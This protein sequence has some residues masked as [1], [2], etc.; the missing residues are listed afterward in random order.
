MCQVLLTH[1]QSNLMGCVMD[2]SKRKMSF[3]AFLAIIVG[4]IT[5]LAGG[6]HVWA[7][8]PVLGS[9]AQM[10]LAERYQVRRSGD[11]TGPVVV[12]IP[13]L[14]SSAEV[15]DDFVQPEW[16][17]HQITLAGF[18]GLPAPEAPAPFITTAGQAVAAYIQAEG[19]EDVILVGHSLGAQVALVTA[20]LASEDVAHVMVVDSVPFFAA[21][22]QPGADPAQITARYDMMVAQMS[23]TPRETF[24]AMMEQ[25]MPIQASAPESQALIMEWV[26]AS[27]QS[28]VAVASAE[29]FAG[30][31]RSNLDAVQSPVTLVYPQTPGFDPESVAQRYAAQYE[32]V[33]AFEMRAVADS[34]HFIMLDQPDVFTQELA[35]IVEGAIQ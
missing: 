6:A 27:D 26:S 9:Q 33:D 21:L 30:D 24:L 13:G 3:G 11:E 29:V 20:G 1:R 10:A 7:Q 16:D 25:G 32:G 5:A 23:A 18:A 12:F 31:L 4:V 15:F 34:R 2:K 35:R 22:M 19:L 14:A 17:N 8:E 28:V